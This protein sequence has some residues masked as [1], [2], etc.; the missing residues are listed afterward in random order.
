MSEEKVEPQKVESL[1]GSVQTIVEGYVSQAR[2][3]DTLDL[4]LSA[5][6]MNEDGRYGLRIDDQS[7]ATMML[8]FPNDDEW[9]KTQGLFTAGLSHMLRAWVNRK[10]DEAAAE[11]EAADA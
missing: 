3:F 10:L 1:L 4:E 2:L 11:E 9:A 7:G 6:E 5:V 8:L